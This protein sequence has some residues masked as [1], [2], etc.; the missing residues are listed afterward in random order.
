MKWVHTEV[1]PRFENVFPRGEW[2]EWL[3]LWDKL[4]DRFGAISISSKWVILRV[5]EEW[6]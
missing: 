4:G 1:Y 6:L 5:L 3:E 2:T